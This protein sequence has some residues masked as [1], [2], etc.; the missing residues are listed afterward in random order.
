MVP[1]FYNSVYEIGG[2]APRHGMEMSGHL[3]VSVILLSGAY[4]YC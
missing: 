2:K 3:H 1:R 4:F